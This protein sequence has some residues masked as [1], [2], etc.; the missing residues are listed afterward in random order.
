MF[1]L[2]QLAQAEPDF[3]FAVHDMVVPLQ[4]GESLIH[5]L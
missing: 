1:D 3:H 4:S 5:T 2:S